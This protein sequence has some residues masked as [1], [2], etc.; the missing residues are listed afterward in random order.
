VKPEILIVKAIYVPALAA[1]ERDFT[2]HKLWTVPD[3]DIYM[4]REIR[5]ERTR[6]LLADL[7][8]FF[9]GQPLLHPVNG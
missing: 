7:G 2:V 4:R 1:L 3:P 6:K 9:S 8:A 5:E